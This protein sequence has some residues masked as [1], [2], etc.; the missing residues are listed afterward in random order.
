MDEVIISEINKI[1]VNPKS[2]IPT[3]TTRLELYDGKIYKEPGF[4][5]ETTVD[6]K[7]AVE[8][9]IAY[10]NTAPD[11]APVRRLQDEWK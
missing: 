9:L 3:L 4:F 6:G 1:R 11:V 2:I 7:T 5:G 10:L 8:E